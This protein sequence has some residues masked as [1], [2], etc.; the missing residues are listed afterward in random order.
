MASSSSGGAS[1]LSRWRPA[2]LAIIGLTAVY[3]IYQVHTAVYTTPPNQQQSKLRRRN[4]IHRSNIQRTAP[5]VPTGPETPNDLLGQRA[6]GLAQ[7]A[8][9]NL[10][11]VYLTRMARS[12]Y[13]MVAIES[14]SGVRMSVTLHPRTLPSR[15]QLST[16]YI[17]DESRVE[18][19]RN[20]L[21]AV[22][23][24]AFLHAELPGGNHISPQD[25][26]YL[27]RRLSNR[28]IQASNV[29]QAV[30]RYNSNALESPLNLDIEPQQSTDL[31]QSSGNLLFRP[32]PDDQ[33]FP[34]EQ[35]R[36]STP[37][38]TVQDTI[39]H[40]TDVG[41]DGNDGDEGG[42]DDQE[43]LAL[44]F[45][46]AED[47]A[48]RDGYVHR[49][50]TCNSCDMMPVRGTRYRCSNCPDYD[51]CETCEAQQVHYKTHL[52]Y[53][54]R[55]PAPFIGNPRQAQPVCYPG[56]PSK[57]PSILL[58]SKKVEFRLLTAFEFTELD[59]LWDQFKCLSA[60]EWPRD[61]H[62]LGMAI[63]RKTFD[64]S[65][66]C[67][68]SVKPPPPNLLYDRMFAYYDTN[69]DGLIGFEEFITGLAS[70]RM[71]TSHDRTKRIFNGY[72]LDGDGYI[73]RRDVLRMFRAFYALSKELSRDS[74]GHQEEEFLDASSTRELIEG[75]QPLSSAFIGQIN[76]GETSRVGDRKRPGANGDLQT[77]GDT[78]VVRESEE[79][80]A[81]Q[82]RIIADAAQ[83]SLERSYEHRNRWA[84]MILPGADPPSP[85]LASV[86]R[87]R[88][89]E[90]LRMRDAINAE[91]QHEIIANGVENGP[92][93][94]EGDS[95]DDDGNQPLPGF[96]SLED[97]ETVLGHPYVPDQ[98]LS[99]FRTRLEIIQLA[100]A[101]ILQE[102]A[103]TLE[104]T[105]QGSVK[106]RWRRRQFYIDEEEGMKAPEGFDSADDV[107]P[108]QVNG[109][110]DD[111]VNGAGVDSSVTAKTRDPSSRSRSSSKVRFEDELSDAEL[112]TRSNGSVSSRSIPIGERWGGYEIPVAE[113]DAGK[114]FLYQVTQQAL[115]EIVDRVFKEKED[116]AMEVFE[117]AD[118]R[119]RLAHI[120]SYFRTIR[121]RSASPHKSFFEE[122]MKDVN[123]KFDTLWT[124]LSDLPPPP[125]YSDSP[126]PSTPSYDRQYGNIT[127]IIL[128]EEQHKSSL[129]DLLWSSYFLSRPAGFPAQEWEQARDTKT[130]PDPT[131]PQNR[132]E[133]PPSRPQQPSPEQVLRPAN[134]IRS[135]TLQGPL[136]AQ[137][138]AEIK[139]LKRLIQLEI[140]EQ[141]IRERGGA[142]GRINL[143]EF[144]AL[145]NEHS[146]LGFLGNWIEMGNF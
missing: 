50:V 68:I 81:D 143:D 109:Y 53:K 19:V 80:S 74:I 72:D 141:E 20:A 117:T 87:N 89:Y 118:E 120:L 138:M 113:K 38:E 122:M 18:D 1:T 130:R 37:N 133:P 119:R 129:E 57:S 11:T 88:R 2:I 114:E 100:K 96:V 49:G 52:M 54:V 64:K 125:S 56:K 135:K 116:L 112:E 14:D 136:P 75:S 106:E 121:P 66:I 25:E 134:N 51:L 101:R 79:D 7:N 32:A 31:P 39:E 107:N 69:N 111:Y 131:L 102:K 6:S 60:T 85:I 97:I 43:L 127:P 82:Q 92:Y 77:L 45:N 59:G 128:E 44:L 63:D 58:S 24:D 104:S 84:S 46:I 90:S 76:P 30:L 33:E 42:E 137:N 5:S 27:A 29:R 139:H 17:T 99:S 28:G 4:A 146:E 8:L 13:G 16:V 115:N 22:F 70:L 62:E 10:E 34:E 98:D 71:K 41:P 36:P 73:N 123:A 105:R 95:K 78:S 140:F 40:T 103:D 15:E 91:S 86:E 61:P 110:K 83:R 47:K 26:N 3:G 9:E 94:E 124:S 93:E 21:E 142:G 132:P 23:L 145:L 12:Q 65:F 35:N 55:I 144:A 67:S 48:R 108:S 126:Q